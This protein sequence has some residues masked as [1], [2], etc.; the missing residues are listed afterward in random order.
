MADKQKLRDMLDDIVNNND[1]EAE[2]AL[3]NFSTERMKE[4]LHGTKEDEDKD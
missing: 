1:E 2:I 3:H 4:I